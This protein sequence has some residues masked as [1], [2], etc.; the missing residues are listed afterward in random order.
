MQMSIP[1]AVGIDDD[2][3]AQS[4]APDE[5]AQYWVDCLRRVG[6]ERD[7]EAFRELFAHFAPLVKSFAYKVPSL[8]QPDVFAEDLLQETM[9]KVWTRA[10]SFDPMLACPST[11]VFAIARNMRIDLLRRQSRH[12]V[13][14]VPLYHDEED[15]GINMEDIWFEDEHGDVFNQ[16]VLQRSR[17]Q[18]HESL[19]T[20]SPEQTAVLAKVYLEDKSHSEVAQEL[21]LPLGT[22]KSRVRLAL[23]KLKLLVDR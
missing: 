12:V 8:E 2:D 9:L 17:K 18:I 6:I 23:N 22:V 11:W 21:Q 16:L 1:P 13:N 3:Q 15:G 10:A 4:A 5:R 14:A 7:T 20:L 19:K